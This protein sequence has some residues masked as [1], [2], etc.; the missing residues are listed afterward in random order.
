MTDSD[1]HVQHQ[2]I[3]TH[4]D[5]TRDDIHIELWTDGYSVRVT[6]GDDEDSEQGRPAVDTLL[7]KYQAVGYQVAHDYPVNDPE[8]ES[9]E[10]ADRPEQC[11]ECGSEIEYQSEHAEHG[12]SGPAWLCLGCRW[13]EWITP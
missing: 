4:P 13:G 12:R 1:A 6:G 2:W 5:D 3:L 10:P 8:P 7:A 9:A 11:P